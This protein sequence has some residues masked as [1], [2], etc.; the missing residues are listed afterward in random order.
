MPTSL[1]LLR[2][3]EWVIVKLPALDSG[4]S[5][6]LV[7]GFFWASYDRHH[8]V[9]I[10]SLSFFFAAFL[11]SDLPLKKAIALLDLCGKKE[12]MDHMCLPEGGGRHSSRRST[13]CVFSF[14]FN[15]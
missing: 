3:I 7:S 5:D 11:F 15:L 1:L 2:I 13:Y 12:S 6:D 4:S 14:S 10:S 9:H 8:L